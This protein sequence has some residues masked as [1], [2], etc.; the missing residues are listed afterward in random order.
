[1][2][3]SEFIPLDGA[4]FVVNKT[5]YTIRAKMRSAIYPYRHDYVDLCAEHKDEQGK[6]W[7]LDLKQSE[8]ITCE[9]LFAKMQKKLAGN[10]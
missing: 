8:S 3:Y 4:T 7:F 6:T 10:K 5:K 1:M 2:I 9:K